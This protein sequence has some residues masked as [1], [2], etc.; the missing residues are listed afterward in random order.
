MIHNPEVACLSIQP[1][2]Q[3]HDA[4]DMRHTHASAASRVQL[5]SHAKRKNSG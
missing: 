3:D 1:I 2:H 5:M 4:P